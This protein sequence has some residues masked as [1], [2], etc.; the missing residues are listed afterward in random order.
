MKSHEADEWVKPHKLTEETIAFFKKRTMNDLIDGRV[1]YYEKEKNIEM[2]DKK[3]GK[4]K[5]N[6]FVQKKGENVF[7]K[8]FKDKYTEEPKKDGD[9]Y[10]LIDYKNCNTS[11]KV[12]GQIR[13]LI[14]F[15]WCTSEII[16]QFLHTVEAIHVTRTGELLFKSEGR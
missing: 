7:F 4:L 8:V 14:G 11:D 9:I 16:D 3:R 2:V 6:V 1:S 13:Y 15:D 5:K 12:L 10:G